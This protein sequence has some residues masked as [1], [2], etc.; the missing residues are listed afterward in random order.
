MWARLVQRTGNNQQ[1]Y[2]TVRMSYHARSWQ[3][4]SSLLWA[5][6]RCTNSQPTLRRSC[7]PSP[8]HI[9][10]VMWGANTKPT[11]MNQYILITLLITQVVININISSRTFFLHPNG[12]FYESHPMVK[13][14]R[15]A[16]NHWNT[17]RLGLPVK[18]PP[19]GNWK[20]KK[21]SKTQET[22]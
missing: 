16:N 13:I 11:V 2:L 15:C 10:S 17:A 4:R 21:Q 20:K 12:L 1:I 19:R 14:I 22:K 18:I 6:P 5:P 7:I 8:W 3:L 9:P